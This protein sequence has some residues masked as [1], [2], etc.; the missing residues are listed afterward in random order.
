M[1]SNYSELLSRSGLW[2]EATDA[3]VRALAIFER[4]ADTDGL[5]V[6][7]ALV[8]LGLALVGAGKTAEACPFL[9][10]ANRIGEA[11]APSVAH[12]AQARFALARAV[13]EADR[14]R[15]VAL[16]R[17]ARHEY[18]GSPQTPATERELRGLD[19]WLAARVTIV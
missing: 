18:A 4:E 10:R 9:E 11:R 1:L 2:D 19:A 14:G 7:V 5:F 15:A 8:A 13:W 6:F 3:A 16:A 17:T 12:R